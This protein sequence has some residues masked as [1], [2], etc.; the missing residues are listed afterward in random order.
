M[1]F[2]CWISLALL[3][4]FGVIAVNLDVSHNFKIVVGLYKA[5]LR[6][7]LCREHIIYSNDDIMKNMDCIRFIDKW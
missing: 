1:G 7:F 2:S 6:Y 3:E 4:V 5:S